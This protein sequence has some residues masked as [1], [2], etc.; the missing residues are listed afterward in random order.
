MVPWV[1][2]KNR[3]GQFTPPPSGGAPGGG[4]NPNFFVYAWILMGI[5][6]KLV[7]MDPWVQIKNRVGQFTPAPLRGGSEILTFLFMLGFLWG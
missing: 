3:V 4:K 2:I 6:R 5:K 7:V 1:Q